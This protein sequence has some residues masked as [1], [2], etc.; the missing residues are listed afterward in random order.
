MILLILFVTLFS[1]CTKESLPP[2][3]QWQVFHARELIED[4][5]PPI[6]RSLVPNNWVRQDTKLTLPVKDT[7]KPICEFLIKEEGKVVRITIHTFPVGI[8]AEWQVKRWKGQFNSMDPFSF[9]EKKISQGGFSGL[10]YES[11]GILQGFPGKMM[12][13]SMLLAPVYEKLLSQN[14]SPFSQIKRADYTI[15]AV[16]P[17]DLM[18][19]HKEDLHCF[20][21]HFELID[22]LPFPP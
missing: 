18:N 21:N 7:T 3:S 11:E 9:Q 19:K 20:A 12:A 8:P 16:G 10:F 13:W 2:S 14:A 17:V 4:T 15:K 22:P 1:S 5:R 6:Y